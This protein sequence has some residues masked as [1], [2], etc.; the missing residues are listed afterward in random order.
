MG[1]LLGV[2]CIIGVGARVPGGP[3]ANMVYLLGV[4]YNRVIIGAFVGFSGNIVIKSSQTEK[5]LQNAAIRGLIIG[6]IVSSATLFGLPDWMD[7]MGLFAG[8]AYGVII[9]LV[10]TYL[11]GT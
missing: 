6:V 3:E 4:W 9:D 10:A 2:L 5:N 11:T 1:G 8:V 7:F